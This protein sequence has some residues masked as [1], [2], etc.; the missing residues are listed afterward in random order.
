MSD[1]DRS[2]KVQSNPVGRFPSDARKQVP[3]AQAT[4]QRF[5]ENS[6]NDPFNDDV[7]SLTDYL[8]IVLRYSRLIV[9]AVLCALAISIVYAYFT[10]PIFTSFAKIELEQ[11]QSDR[12]Q[13]NMYDNPAYVDY[14][15]YFLT[16]KEIL[17]SHQLVAAL[18][19]R[20][21]PGALAEF[22]S[23]SASSLS[24]WIRRVASAWVWAVLGRNLRGE[25]TST[26]DSET[27]ALCE[28]VLKRISVKP[29]KNSSIMA[30]EMDAAD[31]RV[32][33]EMLQKLLDLYLEQALENRRK[34]S[35]QAAG[36]LEE[37]VLK[38]ENKLRETQTQLVDFS[39]DNGIV[40][41]SDGGLAQV[42]AVVNRTMDSHVRSQEAR[43]KIQALHARG[44][45]DQGSLMPEGVKDEYIG[46]LKQELAIMQA[47]HSQ[48]EGVYSA[49][50]PKM[51]M[52]EKKIGFL[53]ERI[54]SIEENLVSSA[55]DSARAEEKFLQQSYQSARAEADRVKSLESQYTL[56]KK[57]V[58][59]NSE[60]HKMLLREYKQ[61]EI[62]A[63]TI[64]NNVRIL[65]PAGFPRTPS[66]PK[67]KLVVLIGVTIGLM[68]G[69]G[70]AFVLNASDQTIRS[71]QE[72]EEDLHVKR[73]GILPDVKDLPQ[74]RGICGAG[75]NIDFVAHRYPKSPMSDAIRNLETSI[76]LS[77][78]DRSVRSIA[79]SSAAPGEGKTTVAISL[80]TVLG[81]D[82]KN[83]VVIVDA[84]LRRPRIH[85]SF[86]LNGNKP[87][88]SSLLDGSV[89]NIS[90]VCRGTDIPGV[91][92]IPSG[93]IPKDPVALLRTDK[94]RRITTLLKK[95]FT[96]VVFDTAPVLGFADTPL[97][98]RVID[99]LIMV[100]G[101]GLVRRDEL[102]Q[103]LQAIR[104]MDENK[105]L[106]VVMNKVGAGR[107]YGYRYRYGGHYY[108]RNY[109]YY[110]G[111]K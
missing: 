56:L 58:E 23:G 102:K 92:C 75:E 13:E 108:Y 49:D 74:I 107:G 94:A 37:E 11:Q 100:V 22:G 109:K 54:T 8:E 45:A 32:A 38:S 46:K 7:Q 31:P 71:P 25:E 53:R 47:E 88:L 35:L 55:L 4:P 66:K 2:R 10:T 70:A 79:V 104:S 44:A 65:D 78:V 82:P 42:L 50:Y 84:D 73:L 18:L 98:Y 68:V 85:K 77:N 3:R 96:Y 95:H 1:H 51:K 12:S 63:R 36:W 17:T 26:Q 59:T 90:K 28:A 40:D 27:D 72:I 41:L 76:F 61:A 34:Q 83:K 69:V 57:D 21:D 39:I 24:R 67:K 16:Q 103:A 20:M 106:G 80:A 19:E 52:L 110:S 62:R 60:L 15:S 101:Q 87:G 99:G 86:G 30:V 81:S 6:L 14:Q 5:P 105:L 64:S 97:I 93:P 33:Q 29:V 9:G 111:L 48:M 91:Y 43:A 89:T